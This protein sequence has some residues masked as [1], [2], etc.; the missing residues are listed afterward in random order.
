MNVAGTY[1]TCTPQ[2]GEKFKYEG[3]VFGNGAE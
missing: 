2:L 3:D 1:S